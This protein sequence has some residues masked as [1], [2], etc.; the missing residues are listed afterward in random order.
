VL[1]VTAGELSARWV[2]SSLEAFHQKS[3]RLYDHKESIKDTW[4]NPFKN[5]TLNVRFTIGVIRQFWSIPSYIQFHIE[6]YH[7]IQWYTL[8]FVY[9]VSSDFKR[10]P[11]RKRSFLPKT[12]LPDALERHRFG[13]RALIFGGVA[14]SLGKVGFWVDS[15]IFNGNFRILKWRYVSTILRLY[16]VGIFPYIGL[17]NRP[18]M[19]GRYLQFR[20]LKWPLIDCPKLYNTWCIKQESIYSKSNFGLQ[21]QLCI[22]IDWL[23][24]LT[25][26]WG[27]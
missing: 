18:Y 11:P 4:A 10:A 3:P 6:P 27:P 25:T 20:V 19:Y 5:N 9:F 21:F 14:Q 7:D 12:S 26:G 24:L 22:V 2:R 8:F 16:F 15:M 13:D 17:N 23:E 1:V